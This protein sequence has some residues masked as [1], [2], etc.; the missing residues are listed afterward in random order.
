MV[1]VISWITSLLDRVLKIPINQSH[2]E[3]QP[4]KIRYKMGIKIPILI[5]FELNTGA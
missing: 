1:K 4:W 3:S 5:G 2:W